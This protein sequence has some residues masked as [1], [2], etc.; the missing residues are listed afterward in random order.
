MVTKRERMRRH[1]RWYRINRFN[2]REI[3]EE[4]FSEFFGGST[5]FQSGRIVDIWRKGS[6]KEYDMNREE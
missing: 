4:E 6:R 2:R 3:V 1:L 5:H